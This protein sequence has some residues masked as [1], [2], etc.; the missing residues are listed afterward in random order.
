MSS[1]TLLAPPPAPSSK[2]Y[3]R[4]LGLLCERVPFPTWHMMRQLKR[5]TSPSQQTFL[6]TIFWD[7]IMIWARR[8]VETHDMNFVA[9]IMLRKLKVSMWGS[10][11]GTFNTMFIFT[12]TF[13]ALEYNTS[14][15]ERKDREG[16]K[17]C[18]CRIVS[19]AWFSWRGPTL[20][21]LSADLWSGPSLLFFFSQV[22]SHVFR[23]PPQ[24]CQKIDNAQNCIYNFPPYM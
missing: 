5:C 7:D 9:I 8:P 10:Q 4:Y 3:V 6:L 13:G 14:N 20:L 23:L 12:C 21:W 17:G 11:C 24:K 16:E 15:R 2:P 18:L 22:V 19:K 1:S